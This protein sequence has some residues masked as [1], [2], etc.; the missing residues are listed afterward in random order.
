MIL[1]RLHFT[2]ERW[3]K[4]KE[5]GVWVSNQGSVRLMKDKSWLS[6]RVNTSGYL[7]VFTEKGSIAVHRLVAYTW[8]GDRRNEKYTIDHINSNKRD[9][10]VRNLRWVSEEVNQ[11]Y[12]RFTQT[13]VIERKETIADT[14][15]EED[16]DLWGCLNNPQ[17]EENMRGEAMIKLLK[18]NKIIL[19][20]DQQQVNTYLDLT[21][22]N[23]IMAKTQI[24]K[25]AGRICKVANK[26]KLY[27]NHLWY[28]ERSF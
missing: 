3:R 10:S 21:D 14:S 24:E 5:F 1:P 19:R 13:D 9:N 18:R 2:L 22:Y 11:E 8:L 27:C 6:P 26:Y 20:W 4:N 25:F 15:I 16:E 17:I 7:M 28:I 12:A 23:N